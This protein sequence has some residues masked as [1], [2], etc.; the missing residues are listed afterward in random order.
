MT[1]LDRSHLYG[2]ALFET[3]RVEEGGPVALGRHID[4]FTRSAR[5]LGY[6]EENVLAGISALAALADASPGVHRVTVSR[7]DEDAPFAGSAAVT[8]VRRDL[9]FNGRPRLVTMHG[10]YFPT[11]VLAEHKTTSYVR[12]VE[13]RR[14]ARKVGGDDALLVSE[15]GLIGEASTS[16]VFFE[17]PSGIVTPPVRGIL[18]GVTRGRVLEALDVLVRPVTLRDL[19]HVIGIALT[20]AAHIAIAAVDVDGRGLNDHLARDIIEALH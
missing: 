11:D 1:E 19:D 20:N 7:D 2:D 12:N 3:V 10:W 14:R 18:P 9:P 17:M 13:A 4:R 6:P 16:N 5:A 8:R 15:D